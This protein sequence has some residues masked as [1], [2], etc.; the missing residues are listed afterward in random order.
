MTLSPRQ[1]A[2]KVAY[3]FAPEGLVREMLTD[4][5]TTT[6]QAAL[7]VE[8]VRWRDRLKHAE[9]A[10]QAA[11][12][13]VQRWKTHS[14]NHHESLRGI[15]AMAPSEGARMQQWAKDALSGYTEPLESTLLQAVDE[16]NAALEDLARATKERDGL[17]AALCTL[18][19]DHSC[20]RQWLRENGYSAIAD[21]L[22]FPAST[23]LAAHDRRVAARV[24]R[25]AESLVPG[26]LLLTLAYEYEDGER[27]VPG[28]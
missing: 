17:A 7:N 9:A 13:N 19:Q 11:L 25:H 8:L 22:E 10:L 24:L 20:D 14:L 12:E 18:Q 28:E 3:H 5:I 27:E 23:I 2:E 6:I 26:P 1:R 16:K 15:A 4:F 21:A